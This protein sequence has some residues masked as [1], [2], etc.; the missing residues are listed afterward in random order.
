MTVKESLPARPMH[1]ESKSIH[2]SCFLFKYTS[3][4]E[5]TIPSQTSLL[6]Q[7]MPRGGN[8]LGLRY[9]SGPVSFI[10]TLGLD[11]AINKPFGLKGRP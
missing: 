9:A 1:I 2:C 8:S 7:Y 5:P 11:Q 10:Q 4:A 6:S 3:I